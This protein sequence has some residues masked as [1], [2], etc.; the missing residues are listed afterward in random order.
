MRPLTLLFA[1][2][3]L[4]ACL[5]AQTQAPHPP[6]GPGGPQAVV[7][8]DGSRIRPAEVDRF[9]EGLMRKARVTGL[10]LAVLN[11][12]EIV[13]LKAF[14]VRNVA[15]NELL[16]VNSVMYGASLTKSAFAYMVMQLVDEKGIDLDK[17]VTEYLS[18]PLPEFPKY[19]DL[20][21]DERYKRITARMLL[22]HTAG[23]PNS[24]Y[25]NDNAKLDIKFT[26]GTRYAYSGEG[27]NLLGFV[28][29]QITGRSIG[30]LMRTRVFDRFGMARTSMVWEPRF[31]SDYADGYDAQGKLIE[32]TRMQY[33]RAAGSMDTTVTDYAKLLRGL[34]RG[35]GLSPASRE[36]M[37]SPQ[38]RIQSGKQFPTLAMETTTENDGI[39]LSYGLGWGLFWSP[40]GKAFF[41][42]GHDAGTEN[43]AVCF[44]ER[45]TC[46]LVLT[47]S[48]N[49]HSLF[50]DLLEAVLADRF[51][52]WNWNDYI[53]FSR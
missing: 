33:A 26:P 5:A 24:R 39:K 34:L 31:A 17:P 12:S 50:K 30:A 36:Q 37:L 46:L 4:T 8:L 18:K 27:I 47:N 7:R 11:R 53:P 43:H 14:G 16:T 2:A 3:L 48:S 49:G 40:Y 13:Y 25:L 22:S 41:K 20:R 52:P 15:R 28:V 21:A 9:V 6:K 32:H 38:I 19:A 45:K 44:D 35:E 29:E 10:A 51:T 42:E 23:F 1:T